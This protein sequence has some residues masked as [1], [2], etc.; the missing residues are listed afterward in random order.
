MAENLHVTIVSKFCELQ[1]PGALRACPGMN[2]DSFTF[3]IA[4]IGINL[5][6]I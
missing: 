3:T 4:T 2:M 6:D 1:P 5:T